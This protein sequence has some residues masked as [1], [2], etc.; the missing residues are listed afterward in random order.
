MVVAQYCCWLEVTF[1][2]NTE[3]SYSERAVL[4]KGLPIVLLKGPDARIYLES[5]LEI[6]FPLFAA[7]RWQISKVAKLC[8]GLL[9]EV[10]QLF[11]K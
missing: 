4:A 9:H 1:E 2:E 3:C 11:P 6:A 10:Q 8:S 5:F 7:V